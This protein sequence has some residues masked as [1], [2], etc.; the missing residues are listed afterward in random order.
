MQSFLIVSKNLDFIKGEIEKIKKKIDVSPF[1]IHEIKSESALLIEDVRQLSKILSLKPYGGGDRLVIINSIENASI[2]A[3]NALLKILEEPPKDSYIIITAQN[4]NNLLPTV[5]SRCQIISETLISKTDKETEVQL[6]DIFKKILASSP[7]E[8]IL[9][10]QGMASSKEEAI[11]LLDALTI[12]LENLLYSPK[13]D[14]EITSREIAQILNKMMAA[15]K[16]LEQNV[17]IKATLDILFLGFPT[18][19]DKI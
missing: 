8:R 3:A 12:F 9:L 18:K 11:K 4:Q 5:V 19:K 6:Q 16:Y 7:G 17:S 10:S 13:K 15:R 1:N 14:L 2:E